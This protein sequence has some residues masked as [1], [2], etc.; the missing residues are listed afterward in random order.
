MLTEFEA[1]HCIAPLINSAGH[2]RIGVVAI[3]TGSAVFDLSTYLTAISRGHY[4]TLQ[5]DG[6]DVYFAMNNVNGGTVDES[7]TTAGN[8]TVCWKIPNGTVQHYQL[9][10][11]FTFLVAKGSVACKLRLHVSSLSPTQGASDV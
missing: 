6:G 2:N 9:V 4:L 10:E 3:G 5:A 8:A 7:N 11:D 1:A